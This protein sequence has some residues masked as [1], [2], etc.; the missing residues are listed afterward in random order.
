MC[1]NSRLMGRNDGAI[2][3]DLNLNVHRRISSSPDSDA[4][5]P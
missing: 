5:M 1:I 3:H 4:L 2:A